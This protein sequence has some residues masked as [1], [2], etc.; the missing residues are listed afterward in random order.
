M[1]V[2]VSQIVNLH[3]IHH[4]CIH[5]FA[6]RTHL[7]FAGRFSIRPDFRRKKQLV[8]IPTRFNNVANDIFGSV[9]HRR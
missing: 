7:S 9:V 8:T 6:G 3:Q 5:P 2:C 1:L 4:A